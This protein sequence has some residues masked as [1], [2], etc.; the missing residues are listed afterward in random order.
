MF[1]TNQRQN[2]YEVPIY[3]LTVLIRRQTPGTVYMKTCKLYLL[4]I[5]A[6]CYFSLAHAKGWHSM[7]SVSTAFYKRK[8]KTAV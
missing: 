5:A 2:K 6:F 4:Y 3:K 8:R 7:G 1:K